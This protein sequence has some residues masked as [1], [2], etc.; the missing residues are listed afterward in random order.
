MVTWVA[1]KRTGN[2]V[3]Q[4]NVNGKPLNLSAP[5]FVK[6]F[7]DGGTEH[8]ELFVQRA[9]LTRLTPNQAYGKRSL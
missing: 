3:V 8:R 2:P 5:A 4:Y 7:I 1:F 9:K 6:K